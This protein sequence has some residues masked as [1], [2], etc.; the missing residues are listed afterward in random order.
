MTKAGDHED[1]FNTINAQLESHGIII[2][3]GALI[4]ASIIP[5]KRKE[6]SRYDVLNQDNEEESPQKTSPEV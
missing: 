6:S 1:V 3:T 5:L 2:K 4:D